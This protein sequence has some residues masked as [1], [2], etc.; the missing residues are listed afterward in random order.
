MASGWDEGENNVD[1]V[2]FYGGGVGEGY[3]FGFEKKEFIQEAN[4][5]FS[6][7]IRGRLKVGKYGSISGEPNLPANVLG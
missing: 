4:D 5:F 6:Y 3:G 1:P 7:K 2:I